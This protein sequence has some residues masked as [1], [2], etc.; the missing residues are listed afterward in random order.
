[1]SDRSTG[2]AAHLERARQALADGA[3]VAMPT[4]AVFGLSVDPANRAAVERLLRLKDRSPAKGLI[5]IAGDSEQLR[6]WLGP[7]DD[8][9]LDR[10]LATWPGPTTWLLPAAADCPALV[11]GAHD[12]I[13][14][15]VTAHPIAAALCRCWGGPLV[16]TSANPSGGAPARAAAEVRE[17]FGAAVDVVID[18]PTGGEERPTEIRDAR[19]GE[20]LRW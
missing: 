12:T 3:I 5:L 15:R 9:S 2:F 10:A 16:S 18:A 8:A 7:V 17:R 13:A 6:A 1:M 20:R 4:E 14:V 19:T 11:R